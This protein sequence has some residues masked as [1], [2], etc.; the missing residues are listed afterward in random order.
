ME[1]E[2]WRRGPDQSAGT[3]SIAAAIW[4]AALS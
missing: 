1:G 4:Y 3:A 2:L